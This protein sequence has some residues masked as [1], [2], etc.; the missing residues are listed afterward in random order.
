MKGICYDI[1]PIAGSS[2]GYR[3]KRSHNRYLEL[4]L[5]AYCPKIK[6]MPLIKLEFQSSVQYYFKYLD[7]RLLM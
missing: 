2:A 5:K 6:L 1:A 3:G 7:I 4:G